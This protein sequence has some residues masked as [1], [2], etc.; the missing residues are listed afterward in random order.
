M[1]EDRVI[2]RIIAPKTDDLAGGWRKV[3]TSE[4]L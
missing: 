1:F 4:L 3:Y 2:R